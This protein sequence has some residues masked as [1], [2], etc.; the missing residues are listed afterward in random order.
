MR[1]EG[2]KDFLHSHRLP[3]SLHSSSP[4]LPFHYKGPPFVSEQLRFG[5]MYLQKVKS[6]SLCTAYFFHQALFCHPRKRPEGK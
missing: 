2:L 3:L 1:E 4:T 6:M 5:L